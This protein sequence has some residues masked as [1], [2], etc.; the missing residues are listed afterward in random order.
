MINPGGEIETLLVP[1]ET[2]DNTMDET[3]DKRGT[4]L[5][6]MDRKKHKEDL[7]GEKKKEEQKGGMEGK[8]DKEHLSLIH[9]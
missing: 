2:S 3:P 6:E 5:T 8:V 7:P 4:S 1:G 9:I